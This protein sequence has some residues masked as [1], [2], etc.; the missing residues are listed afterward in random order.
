MVSSP[1]GKYF[2]S[3]FTALVNLKKMKANNN[4]VVGDFMSLRITSP[5]I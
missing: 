3:F 5:F 4:E 2:G 1:S